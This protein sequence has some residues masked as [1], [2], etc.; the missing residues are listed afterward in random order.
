MVGEGVVI[1]QVTRDANIF[2]DV[3]TERDSGYDIKGGKE[4][5]PEFHATSAAAV[6]LARVNGGEG[7]LVASSASFNEP[8]TL[9]FLGTGVLKC[10]AETGA[11]GTVIGEFPFRVEGEPKEFAV[12]VCRG[13]SLNTCPT[14]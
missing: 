13:Y 12:F 11:R 3:S 8:P 10:D 14:L 6:A 2:D 5:V 7:T 4:T 9:V 1:V